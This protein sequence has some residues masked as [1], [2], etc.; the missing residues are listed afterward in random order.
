M[1]DALGA[2]HQ[3]AGKKENAQE[4]DLSGV[5]TLIFSDYKVNKGIED[6]LRR[7]GADGIVHSC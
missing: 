7:G 5:I 4:K 1:D 2:K 3:F 6:T